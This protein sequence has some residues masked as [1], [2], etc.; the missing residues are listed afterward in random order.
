MPTSALAEIGVHVGESVKTEVDCFGQA[1]NEAAR[2]MAAAEPGQ[3]L[4]SDVVRSLVGDL[5]S[6]DFDTPLNLELKGL[7]GTRKVHPVVVRSE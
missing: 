4:V 6:I 3:I 7:R 2:V 5:P 1:V